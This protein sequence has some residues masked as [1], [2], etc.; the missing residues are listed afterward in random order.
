MTEED[1]KEIKEQNV[2]SPKIPQTSANPPL[3]Q[4]LI[5]NDLDTK[6]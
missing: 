2:I 6:Q 5:D 3:R 4:S 1:E